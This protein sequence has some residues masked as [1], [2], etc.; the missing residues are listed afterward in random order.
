M[1]HLKSHWHIFLDLELVARD[2]QNKS[3]CILM[4]VMKFILWQMAMEDR[5]MSSSALWSVRDCVGYGDC[6]GMV[7][8]WKEP[9]YTQYRDIFM[10]TTF[11]NPIEFFSD[12]DSPRSKCVDLSFEVGKRFPGKCQDLQE[13]KTW[14]KGNVSHFTYVIVI[15]SI[16]KKAMT[17]LCHDYSVYIN[18][19][20]YPQIIP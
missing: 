16:G 13:P 4:Q 9:K 6:L 3:I 20:A 5:S 10:R 18:F 19:D 17:S 12:L 11:P 15:T 14:D 1:N 2:E 8:S 7:S